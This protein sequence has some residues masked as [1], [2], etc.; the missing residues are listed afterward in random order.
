MA[1]TVQSD[2]EFA[3]SV[4]ITDRDTCDMCPMY[5]IERQR[6][7]EDL[8]EA[9]ACI[10]QLVGERRRQRYRIHMWQLAT[11]AT[12]AAALMLAL[13]RGGK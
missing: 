8:I 13:A 6:R 1:T 9:A 3:R 2:R 7:L 5:E 4:G 11:F 12:S 10:S